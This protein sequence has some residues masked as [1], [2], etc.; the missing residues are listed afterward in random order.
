LEIG[1]SMIDQLDEQLGLEE[2]FKKGNKLGNS[3]LGGGKG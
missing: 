2:K 3:K 1:I